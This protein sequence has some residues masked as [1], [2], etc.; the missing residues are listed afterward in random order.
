MEPIELRKTIEDFLIFIDHGMQS[1][2][3]NECNLI[4]YLDKLALAA[5][6]STV[7]YDESNYIGGSDEDEE[8]LRSMICNRFPNYGYYNT[9]GSISEK[10][11]E[12]E[13]E[14]GDAIDDLLDITKELRSISNN[15]D[16][17][18]A[19]KAASAFSAAFYYH[20]GDHLRE[21]QLYLHALNRKR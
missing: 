14:V 16:K 4:T 7:L 18:G 15:W 13:I 2:Q 3:E 5:S 10:I 21:L 6:E 17:L 19:E 8:N 9:P 11:G 12:S 20:I 1:P